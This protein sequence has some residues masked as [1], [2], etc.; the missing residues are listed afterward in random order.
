MH[1]LT[2]GSRRWHCHHVAAVAFAVVATRRT[3]WEGPDRQCAGFQ[4]P[5]DGKCQHGGVAVSDCE[6]ALSSL[7]NDSSN[8][9]GNI[10]ARSALMHLACTSRVNLVNFSSCLHRL[11]GWRYCPRTLA[12][13]TATMAMAMGQSGAE[14]GQGTFGPAIC[15]AHVPAA[16]MACGVDPSTSILE[17]SDV[18]K[19]WATDFGGVVG[20]G[21]GGGNK[22]GDPKEVL[23]TIAGGG[24]G[25]SSIA[26][27]RGGWRWRLPK[28][29]PL[30]L[31]AL[32]ASLARDA[33]AR[34]LLSLLP[35]SLVGVSKTN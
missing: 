1:D 13:V 2:L 19:N 26:T 33:M 34:M 24:G 35:S 14:E 31:P 23:C 22:A 8:G 20:G 27:A 11:P 3:G 15:A 32:Q 4:P 29:L 7:P 28:P 9:G 5:A 16:K 17:W 21:R 12:T 10:I 18:Q 25:N 30:P 6:E